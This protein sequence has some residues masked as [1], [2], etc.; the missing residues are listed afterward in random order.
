M[1]KFSAINEFYLVLLAY[2]IMN[3]KGMLF[4]RSN[5]QYRSKEQKAPN[6]LVY[7]L[8][9]NTFF[10]FFFLPRVSTFKM[11]CKFKPSFYVRVAVIWF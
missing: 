2:G 7:I 11:I 1:A 5:G 4:I 6:H 8:L 10:Y 9:E 3:N